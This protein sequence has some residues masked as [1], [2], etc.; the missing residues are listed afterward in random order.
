[1]RS[2]FSSTLVGLAM[3]LAPSLSYA[4]LPGARGDKA[5]VLYVGYAPGGGYDGYARLISRHLG[6]HIPG[7]P[8]VVVQHRP[9]AGSVALANDL[10]TTLPRDGSVFGMFSNSLHLW[11][12]LGQENIRF[13]SAQF[14]WIG[15]VT[16]AD[17]VMVLRP[18]V[19]VKGLADAKAREITIGVPGSTSSPALTVGAVNSILGTKFRM[20]SGYTGSAETRLAVERGE[21][22]GTQGILWSVDGGWIKQNG[23]K[24]VYRVSTSP[25][26]GL[27]GVPA[28]EDFAESAE[29]RTLLRFFTSFTDVGRALTAP[30]GVPAERVRDLRSAFSATM[31]DEGFIAEAEK[32]GFRIAPLSGEKLQALVLETSSLNEDLKRKARIA[33]GIMSGSSK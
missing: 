31:S 30:P 8:P 6:R 9:G 26:T 2:A 25:I 20:I 33:A 5:V 15:R 17:D 29:Q 16:D 23:L 3:I 7:N 1:M 32:S 13:V 14:N 12:V 11:E 22:D 27:E 18:D 10:Y 4:Q 28:L 21:V 19:G 24:V